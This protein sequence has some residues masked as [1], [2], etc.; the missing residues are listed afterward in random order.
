M[1]ERDTILL[2]YLTVVI[3]KGDVAQLAIK[4]DSSA[5]G[6]I[7]GKARCHHDGARLSLMVVAASHLGEIAF[8]MMPR[9]HQLYADFLPEKASPFGVGVE[10]NVEGGGRGEGEGNMTDGET[11]ADAL[12]FVFVLRVCNHLTDKFGLHTAKMLKAD[13]KAVFGMVVGLILAAIEHDAPECA[14]TEGEIGATAI[15]RGMLLKLFCRHPSGIVIASGEHH[16]YLASGNFGCDFV[17]G[18]EVADI[19][20]VVGNIAV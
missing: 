5:E 7:I 13:G 3:G 20:T 6:C 19:A 15:G 9:E 8:V 4:R 11:V 1:L 16:G 2:V 10:F 17:N 18:R 14:E 12:G